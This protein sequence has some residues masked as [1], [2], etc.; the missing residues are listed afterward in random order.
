MP[1]KALELPRAGVPMRALLAAACLA[2]VLA[3]CTAAPPSAPAGAQRAENVDWSRAEPVEV[4]LTEFSFQPS[5]LTFAANRPYVLRLRNTGTGGH[6]FVA[7]AFFQSAAFRDAPPPA[8]T[9]ELA[10]GETKEIALV[11]LRPGEYPLE[12]THF[13]HE[14]LGMTGQISVR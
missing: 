11:P 6:N 5:R 1:R 8:G 14:L 3:A 4:S 2:A 9:V 12:C 10:R 13:L 7:P